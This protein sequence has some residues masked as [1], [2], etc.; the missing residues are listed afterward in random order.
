MHSEPGKGSSVE[1]SAAVQAAH[2][3]AQS[4]LKKAKRTL[5]RANLGSDH[6]GTDDSSSKR[7]RCSADSLGRRATPRLGSSENALEAMEHRA[8]KKLKAL[9]AII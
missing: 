9:C 7:S 4:S 3:A 6:G 1:S 5:S 2:A 8:G